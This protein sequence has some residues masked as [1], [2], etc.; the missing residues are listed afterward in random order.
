MY[1]LRY[2]TQ[3]GGLIETVIYSAPY[4]VC[5][6]KKKQLCVTTHR[7]GIFKIMKS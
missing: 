4:G 6:W 1:S 7:L 3:D 2:Y 5:A